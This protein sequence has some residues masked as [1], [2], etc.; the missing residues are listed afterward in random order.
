MNSSPI[1]FMD[2]GVGGLTVVREA[3]RQLPHEDI[4]FLGDQARLPYGPRP[5]AQVREFTWQM[6]NFLLRKGIKMLVI[7]CNTATAA[8][9]E[10]LKAKLP[11]PVVGVIVPG[12]RAA[13]KATKNNRIGVIATEGTVASGAYEHAITRRNGDVDVFSLA[14]PKFVPVVESNEYADPIADQI[15]DETLAAMRAKNVDTLVMGC[16]HYPLLRP[17]IQKAMGNGVTLIDSGKETV[18]EV[19]VLLDYFD[20]ATDKDG[21]GT[22][23]FYTT[24]N[25]Q[26]FKE[27]AGNWLQMDSLQA[28]HVD[29]TTEGTDYRDPALEAGNTVVVASSNKGKIAEISEFFAKRGVHVRSLAEF[30]GVVEVDETGTT[31]EE[32]ARLKADGYS[33]QLNLPVIA[34][35]S[36]LMVDA[37]DG[38]PGVFSARYAGRGHNDAANNAKLLAS[39][40]DAES[41]SRTAHFHTTIVLAHPNHPEEDV[42]AH[43][44]VA[45]EITVMPR[46]ENGFGY[47]PFFFLPELGKTMAE[48]TID[49]KNTISHRGRALRELGDMLN[50]RGIL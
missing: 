22:R 19:S 34:D 43:G 8:A 38:A 12:S 46:G 9:L 47:D 26:M 20:L 33:K 45:G 14:A 30:D 48:L 5:A 42:V 32:N 18:S 7:A 25:A 10:D 13:V 44:D 29:I 1:G 31:F 36:G 35:D 2:S 6:T 23:D 28:E 15:V 37:L 40:A 21:Q 11:I 27:I 41:D 3:L 16:T 50:S 39:L 49:Q 17:F 24:G 4:V